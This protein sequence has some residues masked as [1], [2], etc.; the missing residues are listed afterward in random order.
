MHQ[1]MKQIGVVVNQTINE[2]KRLSKQ[3]HMVD[4]PLFG[5][6]FIRDTQG[7]NN[8]EP[9]LKGMYCN[10]PWEWLEVQANGNVYM[11]CATWLPVPI[12]NWFEN[13][14][15]EIWNG[16]RAR[17]VRETILNGSYKWCNKKLCPKIQSNYLT[18]MEKVPAEQ[19]LPHAKFPRHINFSSDESCN[20]SCP[21][22]R[23]SRIQYNEGPDYEHRKKLN[24]EIWDIILAQPNDQIIECHI[25][26]SGDPWGSKVFRDKLLELDLRDKQHIRLK[27]KTNGVMLTEKI[28][29]QM[30]RL[31]D[32][33]DQIGVSW[34][35]ATE[36]TYKITRREGDFKQLQ[37]NMRFINDVAASY[38]NINFHFDFVVQADNYK[39]IHE[40][41]DMKINEYPN[42]RYVMFTVLSD[43]GTWDKQGYESRAVWKETH[44]WYKYLMKELASVPVEKDKWIYW[45]N[46]KGLVDKARK[47]YA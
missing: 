30:W 6:V 41:I 34:D 45:A 22:C 11:C 33:I 31:H 8:P 2:P 23:R 21:S 32:N 29:N 35:A 38:P 26:G 28:W 17:A 9:D 40:C 1:K 25:T 36:P 20:L 10:H 46:F 43:W 14:W 27:F 13:T 44:P 37:K 47:E 16:E 7:L 5:Q 4:D 3:G 24:D 18:P 15:D 19:K 12:G 39:E 42:A